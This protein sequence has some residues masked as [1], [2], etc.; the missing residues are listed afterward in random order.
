[1]HRW[2]VKQFVL[3]AVLL[4]AFDAAWSADPV[5]EKMAVATPRATPSGHTFVVPEGFSLTT[6]EHAVVLRPPEGD[7]TISIVD[8][9]DA[10]DPD[11]AVAKAWAQSLPSMTRKLK[12]STPRSSRNGWDNTR[13]Y[14]YET[15]PN[16]KAVV[17]AVA[18]HATTGRGSPWIAILVDATEAT[19]EKRGGPLGQMFGTLRPLGYSRESLAGRTPHPLDVERIEILKRF[20]A[21]GMKQLD[22]PGVGLSFIDGNKVVYEGGLGV[23]TQGKSDP[24]DAHTVF[25]AASNTKAM[26][27]L[28]LAEAVDAGKL[29]WDEPVVEADPRFKLGDPTLAKRVL[30]RNLVCACTG[31]PRQDLDWL[32]DFKRKAPA[33]IFNTLGQMKP[34]SAYGEVFQYSNLM[35]SAAGYI[36]AAAFLPGVEPGAA[37]DRSMHDRI[38]APLGMNDTTFDFARVLKSDHASPHGETIDGG[39]KLMSMSLNYAVLSA[40]PAGGLWISPHDFSRFVLMELAKGKNVDG[41]RIVSEENLMERRKPQILVGEDVNY[42][43]GLFVDKHLDIEIIHHGGDLFG[44]HSDM[45]WLPAYGIGATILTNSDSGVYLR[46][47]LLRKMLEVLFDAKPEADEQ[48]RTSIANRQTAAKKERERLVIPAAK[49]EAAQLAHTYS[50]AALGGITVSKRGEQLVFDFTDW[51]SMVASRRNDDGTTSFITIDPG[52]AGIEFVVGASDGRKTLILRD[53]QH[54]YEFVEG[55]PKLAAR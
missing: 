20:V 49:Q 8:V 35:V 21:D 51:K 12:L 11:D 43:M 4:C 24:I 31:I 23:K 52:I 10:T 22:V 54:E 7:S 16:E 32:F 37:Y 18:R 30:V 14:D 41:R 39:T 17:F 6:T 15:S 27:T 2:N 28:L 44:Y 36:G 25:I 55:S 19:M 48:L 5:A 13:N 3:C 26:T 38:F 34:T 45:I 50:N 33:S 9:A 53:S 46:G 42:G 47:P 1:M 29:R 40:R